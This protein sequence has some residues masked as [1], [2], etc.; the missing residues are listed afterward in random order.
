MSCN[1]LCHVEGVQQI[2]IFIH[3]SYADLVHPLN[4][5]LDIGI[6]FNGSS[7]RRMY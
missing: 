6:L 4:T 5:I 2:F 3:H 7:R 1:I